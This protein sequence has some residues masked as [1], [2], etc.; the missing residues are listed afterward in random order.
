MNTTLRTKIESEIQIFQK[1]IS[2]LTSDIE[3]EQKEHRA[4]VWASAYPSRRKEGEYRASIQFMQ[5]ELAY[6]QKKLNEEWD[7]LPS[8]ASQGWPNLGF[9]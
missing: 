5:E 8:A 3:D 2:N 1:R 4:Y 7:K 6:T 9:N